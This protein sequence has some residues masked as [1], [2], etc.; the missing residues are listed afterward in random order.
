MVR[1]GKLFLPLDDPRYRGLRRVGHGLYLVVDS[2][3]KPLIVTRVGEDE[4]AAFSSECPHA[5]YQVLTPEGGVLVCASGHGGRFD[6]RGKVI[7]G[8]PP[9]SL[10]KYPA[11]L[12][13]NAV[14]IAGIADGTG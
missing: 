8:P 14:V 9:R 1:D 10:R 3:R 4:V 5:G 12:R 6:L 13:G 11:E 2:G 7:G